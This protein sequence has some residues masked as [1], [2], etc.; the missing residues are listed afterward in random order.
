MNI[1]KSGGTLFLAHEVNMG[2]ASE[3]ANSNEV[4]HKL[5]GW[6]SPPS[7]AQSNFLSHTLN[8]LR[9]ASI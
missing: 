2:R 4:E 7:W 9:G 5:S 6:L 3:P 8:T 1:L